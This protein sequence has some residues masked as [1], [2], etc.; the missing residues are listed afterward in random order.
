MR[1]ITYILLLQ[2]IFSCKTA[3]NYDSELGTYKTVQYT[4]DSTP[5]D[6]TIVLGINKN[7]LT[8]KITGKNNNSSGYAEITLEGKEKY[9]VFKG[10]KFAQYDDNDSSNSDVLGAINNDTIM[11]QNY[12]NSMN[13]Y[14]KFDGCEKYTYL[15]KQ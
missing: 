13:D 3:N 5:C 1:I 8:Y 4:P 15:V 12:G 10:L 6:L 14:I 7:K 2:A 9:I 11:I